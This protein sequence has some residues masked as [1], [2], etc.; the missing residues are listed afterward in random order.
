M[1]LAYVLVP[2]NFKPREHF[3]SKLFSVSLE[4]KH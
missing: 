1:G 2:L 4:S 3:P